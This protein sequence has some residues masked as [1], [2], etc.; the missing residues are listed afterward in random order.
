MLGLLRTCGARVERHESQI[1][2]EN[3]GAA[4]SAKQCELRGSS[5]VTKSGTITRVN[6]V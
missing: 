5:V 4:E 1:R 3:N 6:A 2:D